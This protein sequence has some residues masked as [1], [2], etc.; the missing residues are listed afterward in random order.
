MRA[1]SVEQRLATQPSRHD[2]ATRGVVRDDG[3][4]GQRR[5]LAHDSQQPDLAL[6]RSGVGL[7]REA[8]HERIIKRVGVVVRASPEQVQVGDGSAEH[9]ADALRRQPA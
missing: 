6:D 2:D 3:G 1:G 4:N 9:P 7:L 5:L 8:R